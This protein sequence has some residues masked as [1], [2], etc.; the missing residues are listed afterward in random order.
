[1]PGLHKMAPWDVLGYIFRQGHCA[2]DNKL[3]GIIQVNQMGV[4]RQRD[5]VRYWSNSFRSRLVASVLHW[6][7]NR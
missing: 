2:A 7:G 4:K 1:M 3:A 6:S 5:F